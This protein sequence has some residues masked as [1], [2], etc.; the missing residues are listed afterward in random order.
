MW[1]IF[2]AIAIVGAFVAPRSAEANLLCK[3]FGRCFYES[4][5]FRIRVVDKETGQPLADVHALAE[6]ASYAVGR[7]NG[8]FMVQDATSGPDGMLA[9]PP[10]GP[11]RGYRGGL[12]L[13][14]DPVITLL[15]PGYRTR[16]LNNAFP[17]GAR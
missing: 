4:P 9:F 6:W 13:N 12:V 11:M 5:G 2:A 14:S 1:K 16:V 10:W 7:E 8:P 15:K 3:W 17:I